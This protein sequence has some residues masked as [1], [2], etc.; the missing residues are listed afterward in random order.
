MLH[1][2]VNPASP[3]G[4]S[5]LSVS[6]LPEESH[7][8]NKMKSQEESV[9]SCGLAS[10]VLVLT[11]NYPRI[12]KLAR[13]T[14]RLTDRSDVCGCDC[15]V[16]YRFKPAVWRRAGGRG[17]PARG[18]AAEVVDTSVVPH[19]VTV[20]QFTQHHHSAVDSSILSFYWGSIMK[21]WDDPH[22]HSPIWPLHWPADASESKPPTQRHTLGLWHD[23][24]LVLKLSAV[25][26]PALNCVV[27]YKA[28]WGLKHSIPK[29]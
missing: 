2:W 5:Q 25:A 21:V 14:H 23:Q 24:L 8:T 17:R 7:S 18:G 16:E 26:D 1:R 12:Q 19:G 22:G 10:S 13:R 11:L 3:A 9:T 28:W 15:T 4:R 29:A 6:L 27:R 20:W